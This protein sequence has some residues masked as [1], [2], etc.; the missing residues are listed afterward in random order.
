MCVYLCVCV[1][2]TKKMHLFMAHL[3]P[4]ENVS[5]YFSRN[6]DVFDTNLAKSVHFILQAYIVMSVSA[7][8]GFNH[9]SRKL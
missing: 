1:H 8:Y 5:S 2:N 6:S 3:I 7:R 4:S 9:T